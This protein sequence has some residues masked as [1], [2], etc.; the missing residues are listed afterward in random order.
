[1]L[2]D[3]LDTTRGLVVGL[4]FLTVFLAPGLVLTALGVRRLLRPDTHP[5]AR[6]LRRFG[7]PAEVANAIAAADP[8]Q[9]RGPVELVG[10]WLLCESPRTG[11]TV[12]RANDLVWVHKMVETA[13]GRP[14][15]RV[16][17]YDR[18]GMGFEGR[19]SEEEIEATVA[20]VTQRLPWLVVG[21]DER[22]A[23]QWRDDPASLVPRV[24]EQRREWEERVSRR[25]V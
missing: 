20:A 5:L 14:L 17:L 21:W 16:K 24:E 10:D 12:F 7:P 13:G 18:L 11:Y 9:R 19:G 25:S 1:M 6:A 23:Q 8:P 2:D 4:F 22:V 3:T 15:H